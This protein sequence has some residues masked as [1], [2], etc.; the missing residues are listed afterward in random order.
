MI[1]QRPGGAIGPRFAAHSLSIDDLKMTAETNHPTL[2]AKFVERL[3]S[4]EGLPPPL[5]RAVES[6]RVRMLTR[7][8]RPVEAVVLADTLPAEAREL[9][10]Q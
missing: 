7:M 10:A 8:M 9:H 1:C 6:E 4:L 5:A 3:A 2:R